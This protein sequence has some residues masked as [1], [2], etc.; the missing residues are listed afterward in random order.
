ML[1]QGRLG[2]RRRNLIALTAMHCNV[3]SI[4]ERLQPIATPP[5]I[6][7]GSSAYRFFLCRRD[8]EPASKGF[9]AKGQSHAMAL[10]NVWREQSKVAQNLCKNANNVQ[11]A[12]EKHQQNQVTNHR[13]VALL[14]HIQTYIYVYMRV[15]VRKAAITQREYMR[16]RWWWGSVRVC[17]GRTWARNFTGKSLRIVGNLD[18]HSS[19]VFLHQGA[20]IRH[21]KDD[22]FEFCK[23]CADEMGELKIRKLK[24]KPS[25]KT[26]SRRTAP[27]VEMGPVYSRHTAIAA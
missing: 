23:I 21:I 17:G 3:G 1:P 20:R 10:E 9:H 6:C 13:F 4:G 15:F 18:V 11:K 26:G 2:L 22:C 12:E 14:A 8:L 7:V 25:E 5:E 24:K 27:F 16:R 19:I